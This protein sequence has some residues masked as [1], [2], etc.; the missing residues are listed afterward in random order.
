MPTLVGNL[1]RANA[2]VLHANFPSPY[3]AF[4]VALTSRIRKIPAV[5][6]WHNDLPYVAL[7]ARFLIEAHDG[8]VLPFYIGAYQRVIA[9]SSTYASKSRILPMTGPKLSIIPNG[10]DSNRFT[11]KIDR[12]S[13]R[14]RLRLRHRFTLLFVGALTQWHRYK[15]LDVLLSAMAVTIKEI[16]TSILLIVGDG[17][18]KEIYRLQT[19]KLGIQ[20][21]VH[22]AGNVADDELPRYYAASDALV[23]PS[24]DM[25][26]GFGLTLLEANATGKPVI[27]SNVG[28]IPS[29]VKDGYNGLLVPPNDPQ[30]LSAAIL[31]VASN[32]QHAHDMGHHGRLFA[33]LNDWK[34]IAAKTERVYEEALSH[35]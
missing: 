32:R 31:R 26:E 19:E 6:T 14:C 27:A 9:T 13:I 29:V 3:I 20:A 30:A 33:E 23:L 24:K 5:L 12:I 7:G 18:L 2:D 1:A 35:R 21:N 25:S 10:V 22:F 15:G 8:L 17:E 4:L 16:P 34:E 28:G 11:P